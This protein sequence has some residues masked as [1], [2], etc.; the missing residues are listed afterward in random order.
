MFCWHKYGKVEDGY[1]Y[2]EKCGKAIVSP[3]AHKWKRV[4][5]FDVKDVF[6][7]GRVRYHIYVY[8]C[9]KCGEVKKVST[10]EL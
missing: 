6:L 1:Q 7:N 4:E 2:C 5:A 8:E 3:C 9:E 10:R